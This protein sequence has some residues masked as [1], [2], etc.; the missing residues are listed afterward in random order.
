MKN[1]YILLIIV[2]LFVLCISSCKNNKPEDENP[3]VINNNTDDNDNNPNNN[4]NN[5]DDKNPIVNPNIEILINKINEINPVTIEKEQSINECFNLYNELTEEERKRITNYFKLEKYQNDLKLLFEDDL[6]TRVETY[7]DSLGLDVVELEQNKISYNSIYKYTVN[8][9][10]ISVIINVETSNPIFINDDLVVYH[11]SKDINMGLTFV[12]K[13]SYFEYENSYDV[14]TTIEGYDLKNLKNKK[15]VSGYLYGRSSLTELDLNTLDIVKYAFGGIYI[16]NGKYALSIDNSSILAS[17][18]YLHDYGIRLTLALGG[19]QDD[20][21]AWEPY[22]QMIKST[23]SRKQVIDLL[24]SAVKKYHLDGIDMDW[25]YPSSSDKSNYTLFMKELKEELLK[26]NPN[27]ILGIAVPCGTYSSSMYDYNGLKDVVDYFDVMSYDFDYNGGNTTVHLCNL[28]ASSYTSSSADAGMRYLKG[29]GID[30]SKITLGIAF[31]GHISS[32]V[33]STNNGL[34]QS[35][36]SFTYLTFTDIYNKYLTKQSSTMKRY[37]DSTAHAYYIYDSTNKKFISYDDPDAV[38]EK[39]QYVIDNNYG[40]VMY[41]CHS[42]DKTDL[43]M[44]AI[45]ETLK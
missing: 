38:K 19:W 31:Y 36:S 41:W 33:S 3:Q 40:G 27:G 22:K 9:K 23:S 12:Y 35:Y 25:E 21:S 20:S 39:C 32:D 16:N 18:E 1:K 44:K 4:E 5:P 7:I 42:E 13:C 15:V 10:Q 34:G 37:Y 29:F 30:P 2:L 43:I 28:Y 6:K 24:I 8:D 26:V 14:E 11:T 17:Y 45:S